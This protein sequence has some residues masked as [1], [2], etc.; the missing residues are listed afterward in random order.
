M[1]SSHELRGFNVAHRRAAGWDWLAVSDA[2]PDVLDTVLAKLV[3][4]ATAK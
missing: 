2:S 1:P 4:A 3:R